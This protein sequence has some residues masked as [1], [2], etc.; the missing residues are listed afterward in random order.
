[1]ALRAILIADMAGFSTLCE[2]YGPEVG[3]A[4]VAVMVAKARRIF[5][6]HGGRFVKTWADDV[7]GEFP[8][9][10][11]AQAAG[12][13]LAAAFPCAVGIGFGEVRRV[14]SWRHGFRVVDL[15]GLEV[16]RASRK[17]E[18]EAERGQV[19]ATKA[20]EAALAG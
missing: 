11:Q 13:A 3:R 2:D 16:N 15:W 6:A 8:T 10:A 17:G 9:A 19:L 14:R 12:V 7:M 18:D 20:A 5:R 1:M 4:A